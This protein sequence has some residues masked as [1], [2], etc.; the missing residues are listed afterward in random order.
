MRDLHRH[1][2]DIAARGLLDRII[3]KLSLV[4]QLLR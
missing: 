3:D 1:L 4:S 2:E